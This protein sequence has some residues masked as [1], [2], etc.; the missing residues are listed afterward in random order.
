MA[1]RYSAADAQPRDQVYSVRGYTLVRTAEGHRF[2][3]QLDPSAQPAPVPQDKRVAF[4]AMGRP[5]LQPKLR[6]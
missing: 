5:F 2:Y 1:F 4:D 3:R 6:L